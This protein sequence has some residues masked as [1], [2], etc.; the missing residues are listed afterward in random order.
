[1]AKTIVYPHRGEVKGVVRVPPSKYHLH[2]ALIF[3]SL[4]DG[5]TV[6]RGKSGALHIKDTLRSLQDFGIA[7]KPTE[8]GYRV[9]GGPYKP[10]NG[11]IRVGSSGSTLQFMLGLGSLSEGRPATY[12]GHKALRER[13]IGPLLEALGAVGIGWQAD[14]HKMP[15]TIAPGRPRGGLVQVPGTLSQWISGLL[16]AAPFAAAD[17]VIEALPPVN[18]LTY[19]RLTIQM[20][21]QFGI[22]IEEEP[23]GARWRVPA[24]QTYRATEIAIEPDLSSSAFLLALAALYPADLTL[25]G[26]AGKGTHPENRVLEIVEELGIP[27]AYDPAGEGLRIRHAGIRPTSGLD[28]DMRDIPDLIPVLSVVAAL[29]RGQTVLRNIG[30][31]RMKESNRVK[32][33]LQLNKMGARIEETGDDLVIEGVER[34]KGA[35]ISTYNDHRVQM[36]FTLAGLRSEDGVSALTYPNAYRISYPEFFRHLEAVGVNVREPA[37]SR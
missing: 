8:D 16:I 5:E 15:V 27:L 3:G 24:G 10:R 6:I 26:I 35:A 36:A 17:T 23:G 20:M 7:V 33:M 19:V 2:R 22:V 12:D 14:R 34:L 21:R 11:K 18:E 25:Q 32:A 4:A 13:P 30:P 31:G 9:K 1:M 29:S 37:L 28:I